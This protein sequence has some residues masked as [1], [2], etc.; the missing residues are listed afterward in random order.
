MKHS[1]YF[2]L[3]IVIALVACGEDDYYPK[4]KGYFRIDLPEKNYG[5]Y[6]SE[7]PFQF[8]IPDYS[9]VKP[10]PDYSEENCWFNWYFPRFKATVHLTYRTLNGDLKEHIDIC[11]K[12]AYDHIVKASG[13]EEELVHNTD[14]SAYGLIYNIKGDAASS[15]QFFMTDSTEH[16]LR[17]SLYFHAPPNADSLGVVIDFIKQDILHMSEK[18]QWRSPLLMAT[19]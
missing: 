15:V 1:L 13:I 6:E 2:A 8:E 19:E 14:S 3:L 17:G 12:Y 5:S 16:F 7:C 11:K 9:V 10:H 18:V 4:P